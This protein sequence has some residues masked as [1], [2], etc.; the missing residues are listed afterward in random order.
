MYVEQWLR[1]NLGFD[2]VY[3]WM[4]F[5][6]TF[7][8]T[9]FT[10]RRLCGGFGLALRAGFWPLIVPGVEGTGAIADLPIS[11][12]PYRRFRRAQAVSGFRESAV[13]APESAGNSGIGI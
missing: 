9:Q 5:G 6:F 4:S 3:G 2:A 11:W 8:E 1:S 7:L 10:R 13:E 12:S